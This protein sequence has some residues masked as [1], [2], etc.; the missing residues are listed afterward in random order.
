MM[1]A[2]F[3]LQKAIFATLKA[4]AP[5]AE[6]LGE[7][8]LYDHAPANVVFPYF[9]FGRTTGFDWST[10]TEDGSEHLFTVHAWSKE[11]GKKQTLL[12]LEHVK[13]ALHDTELALDG[14]RLVNL[15]REFEEVRYMDDLAIYHGILRF[16]AV[17]EPTD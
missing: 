8:R 9:T 10:S 7:V 1:S 11:K 5:L 12:M 14:F 6:M 15:R 17:T 16:R 2:T 3:E 4:S 13:A